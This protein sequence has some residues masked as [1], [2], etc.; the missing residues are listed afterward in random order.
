MNQSSVITWL[1]LLAGGLLL[2]A[3]AMFRVTAVNDAHSLIQADLNRPHASV[4]FIRP[5]TEHPM[6][7]ADN[8]LDVE[9]DGEHLMALAKGEYTLVRLKPRDVTVTL[10]NRTQVRGRWEVT[11]MARSRR[12]SFEAG[13]VYF[14]LADMFDGEFRGVH[15]TPRSISLFEAKRAA[16]YLEPAGQARQHPIQNL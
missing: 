5:T 12:F 9:I 15:F 16:Q 4:Y 13:K 6:G 3:C 10:R 8:A 11:A 7:Y 14:V 2:S 1:I